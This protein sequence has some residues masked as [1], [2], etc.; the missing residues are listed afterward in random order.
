M[1][2]ALRIILFTLAGIIVIVAGGL[3]YLDL[4]FE[5]ILQ[6]KL[7]KSLTKSSG[8]VHSV[9]FDKADLGVFGTDVTVTNLSIVP[10]S[11]ASVD[12]LKSR[13]TL[14]AE[15][16]SIKLT[17][18]SLWDYLFDNQVT[19]ST[20]QADQPEITYLKLSRDTSESKEKEKKSSLKGIHVGQVDLSTA[21]VTFGASGGKQHY[22]EGEQI[23]V[24]PLSLAMGKGGLSSLQK[25]SGTVSQYAYH[26]PGGL[27]RWK[28]GGT[29]FRMNEGEITVDSLQLIPQYGKVEFA[30]HLGHQKTRLDLS[31]G[32][33]TVQG[34]LPDSL[35]AAAPQVRAQKIVVD[36]M[37]LGLYMDQRLPDPKKD[38]PMPQERLKEMGAI[39]RVDSLEVNR[40]LI[41]YEEMKEGNKEPG[42]ITFQNISAKGDHLTNEGQ[43][44]DSVITLA[45]NA[46]F[47]GQAAMEVTYA[48]DMVSP[49]HT[50]HIEGELAP[51]QMEIANPMLEHAANLRVQGGQNEGL[52]FNMYLDKNE[53]G[54]DV[55]WL[56]E[57]VNI[58]PLGKNENAGLLDQLKGF[59]AESFILKKNNPSSENEEPRIGQVSNRRVTHKSIFNYSWKSLL[60][61]MK[62][63]MGVKS[64]KGDKSSQGS[65]NN[66]SD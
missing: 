58:V 48:F 53:A 20:V 62:D 5:N 66:K 52:Y 21:Q 59:I 28:V 57:G 29:T 64:N 60:S 22:I 50:V 63:S 34:L 42:R 27:Y 33:I 6:N 61:G 19:L 15:I 24:E 25:T 56:Y 51:C 16:E 49:D 4:N 39:I 9:S 32:K 2:K 17:G 18:F 3:L 44:E 8:Q 35:L 54:G 13:F 43:A 1:S 10:D 40:S 14:R 45:V 65:D 41:T 37:D 31:V 23:T 11:S 38:K 12:S 47:M 55:R 7:R 30:Q 26:P 36:E 46:D